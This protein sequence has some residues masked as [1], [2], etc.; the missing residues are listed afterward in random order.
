MPASMIVA[1]TAMALIVALNVG[2]GILAALHDP[3][4]LLRVAISGGLGALILLGL[5]FGHR[6][7]WQWGRILGILAA[8]LLTLAAV[9]SFFGQR[10][11]RGPA[12]V[13]TLE[14][15]VFLFQ[16]ICLYTIFFALGT[17]SARLF[18]RLRC[19]LCG[20]FTS[21][22]ADFFFNR[23]LCKRCPKAW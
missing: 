5:V 18:F 19:P 20:E 13:R 14:G 10:N 11:I 12:W 16:A 21:T 7:A 23:A 22:A 3:A 1:I 8:V 6:L 4:Q 2:L 17:P 15:G 9:L